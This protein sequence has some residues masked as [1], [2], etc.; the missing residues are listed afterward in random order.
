MKSVLVAGGAGYIGSHACK[1]LAAKGYMPVCYD[2]LS[3]GHRSAVQ[4]GPF[5]E[6][7]TGDRQALLAAMKQYKPVAVMNFAAFSC[8]GESVGDPG[9]Y[10]QNNV[11]NTVTLLQAMADCGIDNIIFSSTCAIYGEPE[12]LPITEDVSKSPINPYGASKWMAER[13][14]RD[15]ESARNI[16]SIC[17][18]YFNAAGSDPDVEIGEDHDP[19]THLI[20]LIL[21]VAAGRRDC[22]KVFGSDYDTPDGTCIRDYIH[23]NDLVEAH[24]LAL[25]SLENGAHSNVYNLGN[26]IGFSVFEVIDCVE[27][28]CALPVKKEIAARRT[29]DPPRLIGSSERAK[30]ELGWSPKL[31]DLE[32]I[33]STAWAW[34]RK[35]GSLEPTA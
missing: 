29:G 23:V 20:P 32:T 7:D 15:F 22:I 14:I 4:W 33:I 8:V 25:R 31:H 6:G 12:V 11:A 2:N 13:I 16:R 28:V 5:V 30:R 27:R 24:I 9:K 19:E 3:T 35:R 1:M 26:G 10:Y 18:R 17:L 34:H 21:D